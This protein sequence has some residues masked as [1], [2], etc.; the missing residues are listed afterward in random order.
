[1]EAATNY[2]FEIQQARR[3]EKNYFLYRTNLADALEHIHNA[4]AILVKEGHNI[5]AVVGRS[6]LDTMTRHVKRYEELM[7]QLEATEQRDEANRDPSRLNEIEEELREHGAEM[8]AVSENLVAEERRALNSMLAM[9]QRIPVAFV[10]VLL[11]LMVDRI[12]DN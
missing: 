1:M 6:D 12:T 8:V 3:F 10:V 4:R 2:T 9:S 11:L 5:T 7:A